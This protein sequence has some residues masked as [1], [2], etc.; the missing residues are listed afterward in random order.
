MKENV[1]AL[2]MNDRY[3]IKIDKLIENAGKKNKGG[4]PAEPIAEYTQSGNSCG[5]EGRM[6]LWQP[7]NVDDMSEQIKGHIRGLLLHLVN[8]AG[9]KQHDIGFEAPHSS[10]IALR[11]FKTHDL[12]L[13]PHGRRISET[14]PDDGSSIL[15]QAWVS[16]TKP[17]EFYIAAPG[18]STEGAAPEPGQMY[19][20]SAFWN[21]VAAAGREQQLQHTKLEFTTHT[22]SVNLQVVPKPQGKP[23]EE[24]EYV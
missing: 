15:L 16:G 8:T 14:P 24:N 10:P 18:L 20:V 9:P 11:D 4:N 17:Q 13:F 3:A 12:K 21:A 23:G 7:F 22:F 1:F 2:F 6:I 5:L 19:C